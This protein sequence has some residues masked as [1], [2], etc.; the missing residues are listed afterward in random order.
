M[1]IIFSLTFSRGLNQDRNTDHDFFRVLEIVS[2]MLHFSL[3]KSQFRAKE[4]LRNLQRKCTK[5]N[6]EKEKG[7]NQFWKVN[8]RNQVYKWKGENQVCR[9]SST[10]SSE[11]ASS[12][13]SLPSIHFPEEI[14]SLLILDPG[15]RK[16]CFRVLCN[17]FL[18][19]RK[20]NRSSHCRLLSGRGVQVFSCERAFC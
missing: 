12:V 13:W 18:S 4:E 19:L 17:P 8:K 15:K 2:F 14:S 9:G 5:L 20:S 10:K 1:Q 16:S 11:T 3:H 7:R 6:F